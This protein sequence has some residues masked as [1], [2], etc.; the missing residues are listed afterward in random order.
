MLGSLVLYRSFRSLFFWEA[1]NEDSPRR[2]ISFPTH[3]YTDVADRSPECAFQDAM[4]VLGNAKASSSWTPW[5][6][7]RKVT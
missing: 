1:P 4:L 7:S 6:T 5:Q 2:V 3:T